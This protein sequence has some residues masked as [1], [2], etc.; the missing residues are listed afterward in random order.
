LLTINLTSVILLVILLPILYK[1]RNFLSVQNSS[2]LHYRLF[3]HTE[4]AEPNI[5]IDSQVTSNGSMF[6]GK[7]VTNRS[8]NINGYI[9][10]WSTLTSSYDWFRVNI[11]HNELTPGTY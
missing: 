11:D 8:K 6:G 4:I 7:I 5:Q 1:T 9:E 10:E 2:K 3:L